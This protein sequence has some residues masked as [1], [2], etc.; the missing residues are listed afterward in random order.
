MDEVV[1]WVDQLWRHP[2]K[3]MQ[4]ERVPSALLADGGI[5][6]DR[7]WGVRS[8]TDPS[9]VLAGKRTPRLLEA[10]ARVTAR[11]ELEVTLPDG[12]KL[13]PGPDADAALSAWLGEP[14]TLEEA[15]PAKPGVYEVPMDDEIVEVPF[16]P[17]T[18]QDSRSSNLHLLSWPTIGGEDVRV[19]RPNVVLLTDIDE[20]GEDAWVGRTM[21]LG[22]AEVTITKPCMRCVLVAQPQP[23]IEADR[24]RLTRLAHRD[25]TLGV[26]A[27]VTAPGRVAVGD[28]VT[29][30]AE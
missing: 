20:F 11:G 29:L 16:R 10:M 5:P 7:H 4:G 6:H 24:G 9:K 3:S 25:L 1:G 8:V 19:Y 22:K 15:D 13:R 12:S 26:Y 18:F 30:L 23:G 28:L 17:G 2:V 21:R 14:V 27:R